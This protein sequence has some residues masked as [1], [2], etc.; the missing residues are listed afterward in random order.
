MEV[1]LG[2]PAPSAAT[3]PTTGAS[4]GELWALV[5]TAQPSAGLASGSE[6]LRVVL[7]ILTALLVL[8]AVVGSL[9]LVSQLA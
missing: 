8:A 3:P 1:G 6:S 2:A 5:E 4:D 7:T 9:V